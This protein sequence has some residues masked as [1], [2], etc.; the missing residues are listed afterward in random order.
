MG[1]VSL[2]V[3]LL[4]KDSDSANEGGLF[5]PSP[6]QPG[7]H[8]E[9]ADPI[10]LPT[11]D[12]REM[13]SPSTVAHV[14][15]ALGDSALALAP[16]DSETHLV[17][18]IQ[19]LIAAD[20]EVH[21][22]ELPEFAMRFGK[23]RPAHVT[24][25]FDISSLREEVAGFDEESRS[26]LE[27]IIEVYAQSLTSLSLEIAVRFRLAQADWYRGGHFKWVARSAGPMHPRPKDDSL[28]RTDLI[29][30]LGPYYADLGF[31]SGDYPDLDSL[32]GEA[33]RMKYLLGQE[34]EPYRLPQ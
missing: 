22:S 3:L 26:V 14:E 31:R 24:K 23:L 5:R 27:P 6:D 21:E 33:D 34:I 25:R 17:T 7:A 8:E 9:R 15:D 13:V 28:F 1:L 11:V 12:G 4:L 20:E 19:D 16:D 18:G 2:S 10:P 32:I 29:V 30:G